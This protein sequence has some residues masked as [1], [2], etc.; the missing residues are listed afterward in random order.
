MANGGLPI[1]R[2]SP[3]PGIW[4]DR[5]ERTV[6]ITGTMELSG[7]EATAARAAT[8]QNTINRT[9]TQNFPDGYSINCNITVRYRVP[10]S[11]ASSNAAQIE[12]AR[13]SEPSNVNTL[14]GMGHKMTLNANEANA[15]TWVPA[16]EFG[17][18]IGM[19]DRYSESIMSRISGTFG[20]R[21]TTTAHRGYAGNLMAESGGA[22]GS[23]NVADL[24][25]ESEPSPF[26]VNDD[27]QVRNWLNAHSRTEIGSLSTMSKLRAIRTLMGGWISDEDVRAI[28]QICGCVTTRL[29]ADKI[30]QGVNLLNMTSIGQ[31]TQ[32]RVIFSRMP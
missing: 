21:R 8:L 10:G 22:L 19:Q 4:V 20:G 31:R 23:R 29:E 12:A 16:H 15:F 27:N 9:W 1:G 18:V 28:G 25:A 14:P 13:V 2:F 24:A 26:W 11:S 6:R 3:A 32:V 17:H 5:T 30:R 7:S